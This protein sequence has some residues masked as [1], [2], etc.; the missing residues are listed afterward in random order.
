[1]EQFHIK[2]KTSL[3]GCVS[4]SGFKNAA[5]AVIPAAICAGDVCI[6]DNIPYLEDVKC[7]IDILENIGAKCEY[8]DSGVLKIDTKNVTP[9]KA[10]FESVKKIRASYYVLGALLGRFKTAE[11]ALPGGCNF[12]SRPIDQH[13]KGLESL[14]AAIKIEHGMIIASCDKL[15]GANIYLDGASV[16]AT[17]NIM[18][19]AVNAEGVTVIENAA[20]EP[21]VVDTA[22]FLNLMGANIKGAGT[23]IIR[24]TGKQPLK[25][26]EYTVIPDMIEAG[27][28]MVAAA[29]TRGDIT[30]NGIIP[31]HLE[32]LTAKLREMNCQ[33]FEGEDYIRVLADGELTGVN[34]K[35]QV[36]PGFP[37]DL[38]PQM[39][40][41]LCTLPG[42]N[43]MTET[44]F[45]NRFQYISELKRL[46]ANIT[47]D[48]RSAIVEGVSNLTETEVSA[49][50][51]RAGVTLMIAAFATIGETVLNNVYFVDRGYEKIE[52]KFK[53]LGGDIV[54]VT[55]A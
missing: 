47:V 17:I 34:V 11:V 54:R 3:S 53:A 29:I 7:Y 24:I 10:D 46:G 37:T 55:K 31:K 44:V 21:H 48:G 51:L 36:Y 52:N 50:D 6:I 40:A 43:I 18:L 16:G 4:V 42:T 26:V 33:V 5:L 15:I 13:I 35:T 2:G 27:T 9:V 1:M 23:D 19:A 25:G 12:G 14:G 39:T 38:Q 22:N 30:V 49:C 32:S 28:F 8:L 41:L 45:E 20:K